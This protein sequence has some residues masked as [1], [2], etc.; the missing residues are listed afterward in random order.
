[1]VRVILF[2]IMAALLVS[3]P[4]ES[5]PPRPI[6]VSTNGFL[7]NQQ[8]AKVLTLTRVEEHLQMSLSIPTNT[9]WTTTPCPYS[10]EYPTA[11]VHDGKCYAGLLFSCGEIYVAER[12]T[13]AHSAY[14]HELGHCILLHLGRDGDPEHKNQEWWNLIGEVKNEARNRGW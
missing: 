8:K 5:G 12:E 4:T 9:W 3:C 13:V 10:D 7:P 11:V 1:M 6:E 2:S 14:I